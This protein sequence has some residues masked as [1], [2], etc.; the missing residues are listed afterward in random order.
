LKTTAVVLKN[1]RSRFFA[2][3][4]KKTVGVMDFCVQMGKI[5][6]FPRL[7]DHGVYP[8]AMPEK[9]RKRYFF[10]EKYEKSQKCLR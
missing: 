6:K 9:A 7:F 3:G 5:G 1:D 2:H 8:F 10:A 4:V